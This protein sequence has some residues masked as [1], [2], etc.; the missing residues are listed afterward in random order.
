MA[1]IPEGIGEC[2]SRHHEQTQFQE[3]CGVPERGERKS[4]TVSVSSGY[5]RMTKTLDMPPGKKQIHKF[6]CIVIDIQLYSH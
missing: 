2:G 3:G 4:P 6:E 1:G 5:D